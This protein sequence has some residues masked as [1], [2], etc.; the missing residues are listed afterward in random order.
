MPI[1]LRSFILVVLMIAMTGCAKPAR[2]AQPAANQALNANVDLPRQPSIS[3]DGAQ[4]VFTWRGD[5]W[6]VSSQ[7]GFAERLTSHVADDTTSAWSRDGKR[8]AFSS[9]RAGGVN[10]FLMNADGTGIN[11]IT[12]SDR[13]L[14]LVG[15]GVDENNNEV[16]TLQAY[17]ETDAYRSPRPY[18]VSTSGGDLVRV[19]DAFGSFPSISPDG[20]RVLFNRGSS[21]WSR[22][23]YDGSDAREVWLYTRADKS[24]KRLTNWKG[25]DGRAKWINNDEFVFTSDRDDNTVNLYRLRAGDD[26]KQAKRLTNYKDT[27]VED[28][29]IS[30]DGR[31]LLFA[32]WNRLNRLD[33][34]QPNSAPVELSI[35]ASEDETDRYQLKDMGRTVT[36][37]ALS[38]DG[39]TM[40]YI[41]YGDVYV[42]GVESKSPARRVTTKPSRERDI[43]WS[44]DSEKL[45]FVSDESGMEAIYSATVKLTRSDVKKQYD[46]ATKKDA[47]TKPVTR[48][49]TG[50]SADETARPTPNEPA[51]SGE[52]D[53]DHE[54]RRRRTEPPEPGATPTTSPAGA[55]SRAGAAAA[56]ADSEPSRWS[57]AL[58]FNIELVSSSDVGDTNPSPSPDGKVLAF[59]RG[60]GDL[61]IM[62]LATKASTPLLH[63]WSDALGWRW[64][65]DSKHIAYTTEDSSN[66][67]DIWI[68]RSNDVASDKHAGHAASAVNVTRHPDNDYDPRWSADGKILAFRSERVND[69]Y[70][71]WSVYL[72]KDLE[73]LTPVEADQYY[74]DAIAAAKKR[75]P[76]SAKSSTTKPRAK[77][78]TT[79]TAATSATKPENDNTKIDAPKEDTSP[80]KEMEASSAATTQSC[81]VVAPKET[82]DL[83]DAY[84]RLRRITSLSGSEGSVELTPGG[85]KFIF[86]ATVGTARSLYSLDRDATEPKRLTTA[87]T[88]Q[89][90]N[91]AG[92]QIVFTDAG[93]GG[94][95]KLPNG[96]V[97]YYDIADRVRVDL[98]AFCVQK[99]LEAS[100]I[101]GAQ[102]WDEKM[103][104]LDWPAHT[105]RYLELA[106]ATRTAEEFDHV[107][108]RMIG[109]L[110]G[111]HLGINAPDPA[112]PNTRAQGRLGVTTIKDPKGFKVTSILPDGPADRGTMKLKIGDVITQ[113][114]L[115]PFKP[116]DTLESALAGKVDKE[117]LVG[118]TRDGQ[119]LAALITTVS[120]DRLDDLAYNHWRR[121]NARKV[122]EWSGGKLGYIHILAMSQPSLDVFERDLYAAAEGKAGLIIDVRNNGGG[123]TADRL[124]ASIMYPRH[125]Y[126]Q[127]RGMGKDIKDAYPQDRLFIQRYD[128]PIDMLCNEKSFSNAEILAH[129]FKTLKRGTLIGEATAGGVISTGGTSLLDGT[130]VRIPGRA[131]YLPDGTNMER[132]GAVPDLRVPQTPEDEVKD[133]DSQLHAAVDDLMKRVK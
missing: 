53:F 12:N 105:K 117:V 61:F 60:S 104:G 21:S 22:R 24:F 80:E 108:N 42:R 55:G 126:T 44:A 67:S 63:G 41:A 20:K 62:T 3:P 77:S 14:G 57:E 56:A 46:A 59:R 121:E 74:K 124:L 48:P 33:L 129:A 83:D 122:E 98:Q 79:T 70:D 5:L 102:Y 69:E 19:H 112:N 81:P 93:R 34:T 114:D 6:K 31:T 29:D 10:F 75:K 92:D 4:V 130:S 87:V 28:F 8:I 38:P 11:Q 71:V 78:S 7:G 85:D 30:A 32:R 107:A 68:A 120:Y 9:N 25:N 52:N 91:F 94:I 131:W 16:L 36:D 100:R 123:S 115:E 113:I 101:L 109:E 110:N 90:L 37:A 45:Y 128:K 127:P 65:P 125:A 82:L 97:E 26:D 43:A 95:V 119:E 1:S 96:E 133:Q 17:F 89:G 64:S 118:F 18:M 73:S 86:T 116:D 27:D 15:F 23:G 72:D 2:A 54:Q 76:L 103:N 39:K 106:R 66:N 88:V 51:K 84:L 58:A 40:A 35:L 47:S 99:F 49:T 13:A 50:P 132:H 111:S